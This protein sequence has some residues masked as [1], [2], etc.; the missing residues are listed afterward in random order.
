MLLRIVSA[1][2][3]GLVI[4]V[5]CSDKNNDEEGKQPAGSGDPSESGY[6]LVITSDDDMRNN[7]NGKVTVQ[8]T[9]G[10]KAVTDAK[11]TK[12]N[13]TIVCGTNDPI[14]LEGLLTEEGKTVISVDLSNKPDD[15]GACKL[16]ATTSINDE[17][18]ESKDVEL[19]TT[20]GRT[21]NDNGQCT[22][23]CDNDTSALT[24]KVGEEIGTDTSLTSG[25]LSLH[26]CTN[27]VLY[28]V[29]GDSVNRATSNSVS[30][31]ATG[32][33]VMFV[34]GKAGSKCV[35]QHTD[36][37]KT[38]TWAKIAA[39]DADENKAAAFRGHADDTKN[40][41]MFKY[42]NKLRAHIPKKPADKTFAVYASKD[43]GATWGTKEKDGGGTERG[44]IT[45]TTSVSF[46]GN[47]PLSHQLLF[48][49]APDTDDTQS[50]ADESKVWWGLYTQHEHV[51]MPAVTIGKA[52]TITGHAHSNS[53]STL[54]FKVKVVED[55]GLHF[56]HIK[57][58]GVVKQRISTTEVDVQSYS[59]QHKGKINMLAIDGGGKTYESGCNIK[60]SIAGY[61]F[62]AASTAEDSARPA[63]S[64]ITVQKHT[65]N[66][67]E[68]YIDI[69][70]PAWNAI[71]GTQ[72]NLAIKFST[73]GGGDWT[74]ELGNV[75]SWDASHKSLSPAWHS[76]ATNNQALV[77]VSVTP[78][79]GSATTW[80]YYA[81]GS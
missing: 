75:S 37:G 25:T 69:T 22:E 41:Y 40:I 10:G 8:L 73:D 52:F 49:V 59:E 44:G 61:E 78:T 30:A 55:C 5:A 71:W 21:A 79:G 80:W 57:G 42:R 67:Q 50:D 35:L 39:A 24:F 72:S 3:L 4:A 68:D 46:D 23:N 11:D 13:L 12:V 27:A 48:R 32:S 64:G 20:D 7:G 47:N 60:L 53:P 15:I 38:V 26:D 63:V 56:F 62:A 18:I 28:S 65:N 1:V 45:F 6:A 16:S 9:K 74:G 34:L 43:K 2:A 81:Q 51:N 31:T 14:K 70:L 17:A 54:I 19:S 58:D 33:P 76:T 66:Q 77:S 36:A 29:D